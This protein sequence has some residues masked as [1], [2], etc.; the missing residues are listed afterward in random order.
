LP[1]TP[2]PAPPPA[3][4][5]PDDPI[6]TRPLAP[7]ILISMFVLMLTVSWSLYN[8][9]FGL[10]PWR[11]YQARFVAAYVP[12]LQKQQKARIKEEQ[13]LYATPD[14]QRLKAAADAAS[15][16]VAPTDHQLTIDV[17]LLDQQRAAMTP[18]FQTSRGL[19]GALTYQ[20]EQIPESDKSAKASKKKELD[21]A[22]AKTF[23]VD[24]PVSAT[25]IEHRNLNYTQL[26]Q[27]FTDLMA[28]KAIKIAAR[29]DADQAAKDA[30]TALADFV[31]TKLPG[32]GSADLE[33]LITSV[34][35]MDIRL[36]Q[37]NVNPSGTQI[38]YLGGVGLVDRCQ[39]CHMGIDPLI[40]PVTM[41]LTKADMGLEHNDD[42]PFASHPDPD[43]LKDHPLEKFGCSPCH[44]GNG[45]ALDTVEK[46][47]GRY[48][49]WLWPLYY[50]EN[51]EAGCQQCHAADM[52]T[53]HGPVITRARELY[54]I[55]GCIGCHRYQGFDNQDEQLVSTR[56]QILQLAADKQSDQLRIAQFNKMGDAAASNDA[57]NALYQQAT[58]LT[59]TI[60]RMD[61]QAEQLEDL[62]H[63]LLQDIKKVGPDL[64]EVRMKL[65]PEWIP[66]WLGHTHE[67]RPTTKMPQFRLQQ[68]EIEAIAAFIWQSGIE[69][70]A[71]PTQAPGDP[72]K[73]KIAL[74][75]RGCLAC[76]S[77]GEGSQMI[78]GDFAAN[79]SR[80]GEKENYDYLVR[81]IHN[82]RDRTRPYDP[83]V[84]RDL[85][86]EDYAKKGL[87]FVF[88][89]DHSRS[90]VDGHELVVEQPTIMPSLRLSWGESRDIASYLM[91]Q[92]HA[93]ASYPPAP[94]LDDPNLKDKGLELVKHYG[95]AGC[96]EISGLEEEGRVGTELTNEGS[97]PIERLDFALFTEDAKE[98]V[99]PDG[100]NSKRGA[101][102]DLKG[103]FEQKLAD[104]GVFDR[105]KYKPDPMDRLRMPKPNLTADDVNK[106]TTLLLGSVDPALPPQ[107]MYTPDDQREAIQKGWWLVT[108]YNCI[109][110]HQI[111]VGQNSVLMGLPQYQGENKA[112][113]PPVL[114]TEGARVNPEW[115]RGFLAN[116]SL[117]DTD[118]DRDGVRSYLQVRMPTFFLSD[119]E[120]RTLVLFFEAMSSQQQPFI[121][122]RLEPLT[123][124][125]V[126]MAR[127]LFTSN[128]APCLK[129]HMT[130]NAAHDKI[131]TA[132]DFLLA[133][134]RL[135][136]AWVERWITDPALIAP[137][138]AM[139]SGLFHQE[140]G[141]WVF[142]GP[143]PPAMQQYDGDNADLL[144]RYM[145][146]L[147]P[148]EEHA[149]LGRTPSGGAAGSGGGAGK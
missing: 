57:A 33:G 4:P 72:A 107:Y 76:H 129:C 85:G 130:G 10:R 28:A 13:A 115:L 48:E 5:P 117:S 3:G 142:S 149:L 134:D 91:T 55:K 38:N 46:A 80:V 42:A 74:E 146:E 2:P 131:A 114:T 148:A 93:D 19:V 119:N 103:F 71:L 47:H 73:G 84:H 36:R 108:K 14:Y 141:R 31:K 29:G 122:Q 135:R 133:K 69:G 94:Y 88:D 102:Y 41:T 8:E 81:W 50:S 64:K 63:N 54:R 109:G 44:G 25:Q 27:T 17:D 89:L 65:R 34:S 126:Q 120:I 75:S 137:G 16:A 43:L 116:P 30:Q 66:Y 53:E 87:P 92:K 121:P 56:Q 79:L 90:P 60:S 23:E 83:Y 35:S 99:L 118:T 123:T 1:E 138:T 77:I 51:Y 106:L 24:W 104:P 110:C 113:L 40:V 95:C 105:G 124:A 20:L 147:T 70:P 18:A 101:W 128:A 139:P 111:D 145:F 67:F 143:L 45:R 26:N 6:T 82:P 11:D 132:P 62:S 136:P 9:F 140:D 37:I 112:Y 96:H 21:D 12:Y 15:A 39:S 49:H 78:G 7:L 86:P 32:L 97:K 61:A 52:V 144:V 100:S 127:D 68:D 98:G 22:M 58:N 59:V 125:E